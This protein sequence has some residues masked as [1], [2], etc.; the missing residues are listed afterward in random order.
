MLRRENP[1]HR[2]LLD[3]EAIARGGVPEQAEQGDEEQAQRGHGTG[4]SSS[5]PRIKRERGGT[6]AP[7]PAVDLTGG[8]Q[9]PRRD[10]STVDACDLTADEE[11][12]QWS[13]KKRALATVL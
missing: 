2:A 3:A 8:M 6:A 4:P 1:V 13:A 9:R 5:K 11:A 10:P 7:G 12:P